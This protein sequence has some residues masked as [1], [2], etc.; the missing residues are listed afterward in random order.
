[1][2]FYAGRIIREPGMANPTL[3]VLTDRKAVSTNNS[4]IFYGFEL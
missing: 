2:A 4:G 3:V 1:M